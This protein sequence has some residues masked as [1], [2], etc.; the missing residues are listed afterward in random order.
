MR[1]DQLKCLKE[2]KKIK[3]NH[4]KKYCKKKIIENKKHPVVV[5]S[6]SSIFYL[7]FYDGGAAKFRVRVCWCSI[8]AAEAASSF[9]HSGNGGGWVP[10]VTFC[11]LKS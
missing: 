8:G 11:Y 1:K 9:V 5:E 4:I 6:R 2:F 7:G 10:V 3:K